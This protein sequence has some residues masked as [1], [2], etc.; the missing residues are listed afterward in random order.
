MHRTQVETWTAA[1]LG[2]LPLRAS[3][4]LVSVYSNIPYHFPSVLPPTRTRS[5]Q[6]SHDTAKH[7]HLHFSGP[8]SGDVFHV[9]QLGIIRRPFHIRS[10]PRAP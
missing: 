4:I 8:E 1:Y 2:G 9:R 3:S 6:L 5:P 10:Q 7:R